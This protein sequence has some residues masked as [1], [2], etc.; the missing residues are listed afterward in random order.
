MQ[1]NVGT[2]NATKKTVTEKLGITLLG[3]TDITHLGADP[4][5]KL[6]RVATWMGIG[7]YSTT[8][9]SFRTMYVEH[10]KTL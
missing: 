8:S 2:G 6:F 5:F 4:S 3:Y 9:I 1:Y 10:N 7:Y